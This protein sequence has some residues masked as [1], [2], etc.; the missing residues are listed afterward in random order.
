MGNSMKCGERLWIGQ[1]RMIAQMIGEILELYM[2]I[3]EV[4]L[5]MAYRW[6]EIKREEN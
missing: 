1:S 3:F 4:N 2:S 6:L 5:W